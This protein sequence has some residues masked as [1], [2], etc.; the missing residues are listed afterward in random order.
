M[1]QE[2]RV[3]EIRVLAQGLANAEHVGKSFQEFIKTVY[4]FAKD[5]G[6]PKDKEMMAAMEREIAKGPISFTPIENNILRD[7]AKKYVMSEENVKKLRAAT[8]KRKV[9]Q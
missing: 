3:A 1:R 4:P 5:I 7:T 6:T 9:G 2:Q 8:D